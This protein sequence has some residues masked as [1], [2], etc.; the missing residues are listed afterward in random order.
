MTE[1]PQ[2]TDVPHMTEP[3]QVT[4]EPVTTYMFPLAS[5]ATAG[6]KALP[7]LAEARSVLAKAACTSR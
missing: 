7:E 4:E 1:V 5:T 6:D 2:T 3:P